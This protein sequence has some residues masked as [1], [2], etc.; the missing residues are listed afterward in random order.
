MV[1]E[2]VHSKKKNDLSAIRLVEMRIRQVERGKSYPSFPPSSD[3]ATGLPCRI[4]S[5]SVDICCRLPFLNRMLEFLHFP[6]L[7]GYLVF[8]ILQ[9][10]QEIGFLGVDSCRDSQRLHD[11]LEREKAETDSGQVLGREAGAAGFV[12]HCQTMGDEEELEVAG[13]CSL[14]HLLVICLVVYAVI[15]GFMIFPVDAL[16]FFIDAVLFFIDAVLF[17]IDAALFSNVS[18]YFLGVSLFFLDMVIFFE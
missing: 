8:R 14:E 3:Y 5:L 15:F 7:F 13:R 6:M 2:Y 11:D 16:L 1:W 10:S 17:F 12:G 4:L 9:L 18:L